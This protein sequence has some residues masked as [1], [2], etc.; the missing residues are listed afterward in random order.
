MKNK[1]VL[2]I[3]VIIVVAVVFSIFRIYN[4]YKLKKVFNEISIAM[5]DLLN[6]CN[7]TYEVKCSGDSVSNM[8][9]WVYNKEKVALQRTN[10]IY[11]ADMTTNEM[12]VANME[13]KTYTILNT[14]ILPQI[15]PEIFLNAPSFYSVTQIQNLE[16]LLVATIKEEKL[17]DEDCYKITMYNEEAWIN[18]ETLMPVKNICSMGE[19]TYSI[20]QNNVTENDVTF[21]DINNFT[22]TH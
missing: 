17:N 18:K 21:K 15:R 3:I 12:Y 6:N 20:T 14:S 8:K 7:F 10:S 4:I 9:K 11:Y 19:Y 13:D 5:G 2:F 22:E 1:K 16:L